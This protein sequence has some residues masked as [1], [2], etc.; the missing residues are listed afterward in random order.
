M[1]L[2]DCENKSCNNV[3]SSICSFS[4]IV[5]TAHKASSVDEAA[6]EDWCYANQIDNCAR[7]LFLSLPKEAQQKVLA[8]G[9]I[10]P[11]ANNPSAL[12][13][14]RISKVYSGWIVLDSKRQQEADK[15]A[16]HRARYVL[17]NSYGFE[18]ET[19]LVMSCLTE[20]ERMQ[21]YRVA[22]Y[23]LLKKF[24]EIGVGDF[25]TKWFLTY[26]K[27]HYHWYVPHFQR[28]TIAESWW[29][30]PFV[31]VKS[32]S[33]PVLRFE[34]PEGRDKGWKSECQICGVNFKAV[35]LWTCAECY[36][37]VCTLC[38]DS[39]V[40][41]LVHCCNCIARVKTKLLP[42]WRRGRNDDE[43]LQRKPKRL[44]SS[45]EWSGS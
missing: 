44:R 18:R 33:K 29:N 12:L 6:L 32:R 42:P 19:V 23:N 41:S 26:R 37:T 40:N 11:W 9:S 3:G 31:T 7:R 30:I 8:M 34:I 38:L 5:M 45:F 39:E 10:V 16:A 15:A 28:S 36:D 35:P 2:S 43:R 27:E 17:E 14:S 13:R 4:D 24:G 1:C 21:M 22:L 20:S 25:M